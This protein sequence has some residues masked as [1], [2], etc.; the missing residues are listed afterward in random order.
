MY[1]ISI[2]LSILKI[3]V[4]LLTNN[5]VKNL[6]KVLIIHEIVMDVYDLAEWCCLI[7]LTEQSL[8]NHSMP[9][10]IPDFT[11]GSRKKLTKLTFAE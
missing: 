5:E 1:G 7:P 11:R 8:D 2:S 4:S 9:E 3:Y 6:F 10:Q